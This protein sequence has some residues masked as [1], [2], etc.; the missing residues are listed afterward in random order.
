MHWL[1]ATAL[2]LVN[3]EFT[4]EMPAQPFDAISLVTLLRV[5][6]KSRP[7]RTKSAASKTG[8]NSLTTKRR[9]VFGFGIR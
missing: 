6:N 9:G 3:P 5:T 8:S 1:T 7:Q 2:E 4:S